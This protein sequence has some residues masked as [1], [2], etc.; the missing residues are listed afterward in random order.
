MTERIRPPAVAGVPEARTWSDAIAISKWMVVGIWYGM[1]HGT[2]W[3]RIA[4]YGMALPA[5]MS[6]ILLP[7]LVYVLMR[8]PAARYYMS[9]NKDAVLGITAR[10]G[11][12]RIADHVSAK[13][14]TGQG[15]ALRDLIVAPL[16]AAA[17]RAGVEVC[18]VAA[19]QQLADQYMG[20][21]PGLVDVGRGQLRG[22][23]LRR[24][25]AGRGV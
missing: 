1:R 18:T 4:S 23:K 7:S 6:L 2:F 22:R 19:T 25:A 8:R 21:V 11:E 16:T 9:P 14:G 3:G 12:W 5:L 24:P 10:R 15:K 13:P 20:A 17:D